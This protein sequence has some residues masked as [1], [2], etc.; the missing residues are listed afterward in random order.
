[1]GLLPL[2]LT[3]LSNR[4]ATVVFIFLRKEPL[5]GDGATPWVMPLQVF[6]TIGNFVEFL[7]LSKLFREFLI[8]C[9]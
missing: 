6:Q 9:R 7:I 3:S 1:V 4:E 8:S 5:V 2:F